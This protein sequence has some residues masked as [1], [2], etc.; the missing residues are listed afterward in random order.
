MNLQIVGIALDLAILIALFVFLSW[1]RWEILKSRQL[2][3]MHATEAVASLVHKELNC[4]LN[5]VW[6]DPLIKFYTQG[7][8]WCVERS[9]DDDWGIILKP[10]VIIFAYP[11][12]GEKFGEPIEMVIVTIDFDDVDKGL[13]IF[14]RDRVDGETDCSPVKFVGVYDL[15]LVGPAVREALIGIKPGQQN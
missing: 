8:K 14:A 10:R 15:H 4:V 12:E 6:C 11:I 1:I 2:F 5:L 9:D 13:H 7:C 3:V